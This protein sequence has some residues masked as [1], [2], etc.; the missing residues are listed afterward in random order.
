MGNELTFEQRALLGKAREA[1]RHAYAPASGF[2]VGAALVTLSGKVFTGCNVESS[3]YSISICAER[4]AL[5]KAVSEGQC[6]FSDLL[7]VAQDGEEDSPPCGACRQALVEFSPEMRV[8]F[9]ENGQFVTRKL[10]DLLPE[11]FG[12]K[13]GEHGRLV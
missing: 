1:A 5:Y 11:A 13:K 3:A 8:T 10:S 4:V 2:K 7:V 9:R 12:W 6:D